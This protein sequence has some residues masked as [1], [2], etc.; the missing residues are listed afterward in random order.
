MD[1]PIQAKRLNLVLIYKKK[2]TSHQM[3]FAVPI[4]HKMKSKKLN[5]YVE[6]TREL[7]K[8]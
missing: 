4:N 2:R 1:H 3:D 8:L 6:L 7:K 5:K